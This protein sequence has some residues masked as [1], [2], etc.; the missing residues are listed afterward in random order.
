MCI[1]FKYI[2]Y[3]IYVSYIIY[4]Q[5]VVYPCQYFVT[6]LY[7]CVCNKTSVFLMT[8]LVELEKHMASLACF[9]FPWQHLEDLSEVETIISTLT[10]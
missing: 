6:F 7:H 8:N 10:N 1:Y 4:G 2:F 5:I 9:S 3:Y